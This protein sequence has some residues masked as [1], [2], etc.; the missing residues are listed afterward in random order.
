[1]KWQLRA[2][3]GWRDLET[4]LE[5]LLDLEGDVFR[6]LQGCHGDEAADWLCRAPEG[7]TRTLECSQR[8]QLTQRRHL[9]AVESSLGRVG[10]PGHLRLR[11]SRKGHLGRARPRC[12]L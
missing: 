7:R 6:W 9:V 3:T 4:V 2:V 1:M 8:R 10:G 5:Q 11:A 12:P